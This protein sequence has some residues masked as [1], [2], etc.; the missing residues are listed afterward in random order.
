MPQT[1]VIHWAVRRALEKQGWQVVTEH[2]YLEEGGY[3]IYIDLALEQGSVAGQ[4]G[5]EEIV[6]EVKS[7]ISPSFMSDFQEALGQYLIYQ[8]QLDENG[9]NRPLFL[10]ISH[11][12]YHRHFTQ[13]RIQR[14]VRKY[15][16]HLLVVDTHAEE[17]WQ[18][19]N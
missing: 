11:N 19:I 17:L 1:D 13:P 2:L 10:A 7:F 18:W 8:D 3:Y 9:D 4:A 5:H 16:I 12:V 14:I 6:V 15:Q